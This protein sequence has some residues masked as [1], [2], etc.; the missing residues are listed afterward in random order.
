MPIFRIAIFRGKR[1]VARDGNGSRTATRWNEGRSS[2]LGRS[3]VSG[4]PLL[5]VKHHEVL[6]LVA[7]RVGYFKV[8]RKRLAVP[9]NRSTGC[10]YGLARSN[11]LELGRV[12]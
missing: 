5:L 9:G 11:Q 12:A 1:T 7:L 8:H 2:K 4:S 6:G 10:T 3:P